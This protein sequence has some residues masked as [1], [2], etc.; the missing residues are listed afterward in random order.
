MNS[1]KRPSGNGMWIVL[2]WNARA[3][4][5]GTGSGSVRSSSS[6]PR[7][8][9]LAA[10]NPEPINTSRDTRPGTGLRDTAGDEAAEGMADQRRTLDPKCVEEG[11]HVGGQLGDGIAGHRACPSRR[12][13]GGLGRSRDSAV[14]TSGI[15]RL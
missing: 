9:S 8:T 11:G 15:T 3:K 13:R 1:S 14:E 4:D 6:T 7:V 12:T 2:A 10:L 5:S